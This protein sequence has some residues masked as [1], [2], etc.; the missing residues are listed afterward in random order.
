MTSW[1]ALMAPAGTP[2]PVIDKLHGEVVRILAL[3]EIR[4][5]LADLGMEIVGNAPAE[6]AALIRTQTPQRAR[7]IQASGAKLQ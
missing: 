3:P 6:L 5:K 4:Q 2:Q 1:F 7:L